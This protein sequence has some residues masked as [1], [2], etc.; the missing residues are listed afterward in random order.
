MGWCCLDAAVGKLFC[1]RG[2]LQEIA[3]LFKHVAAGPVEHPTA[4]PA[5]VDEASVSQGLEVERQK[6]LTSSQRV[7]DLALTTLAITEQ[8]QYPEAGLVR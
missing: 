5:S 2:W 7:F 3:H 8:H 4:L 6:R 1:R